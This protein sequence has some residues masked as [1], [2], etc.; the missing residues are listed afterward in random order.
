ML[1]LDQQTE[2]WN[3]VAGS[4]TFTHPLNKPLFQEL[5]PRHSKILDLGCGYGRI[6]KELVDMGYPNVVGI[7]SS[8][9]MIFEGLTHWPHLDLICSASEKLPITSGSL[10]VVIL[11]AVLTSVPTNTGQ[12]LLINNIV[13]A[14]KPGGA[15][16]ISDYLLQENQRNQMRYEK[17]YEK[18]GCYG[19]FELE[20]GVVLRHHSKEWIERLL[21]PFEDIYFEIQ[22]V[23]T[24]N[25]HKSKIFQYWGKKN[26]V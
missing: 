4:K 7:D 20:E 8:E 26:K 17:Y 25:G 18:Y 14:L 1:P 15:V 22:E 11:F 24:M 3:K 21:K 19:V 9:K 10:D 5:V 23:K 12:E 16:Y 13:Q 6:V 2:Y